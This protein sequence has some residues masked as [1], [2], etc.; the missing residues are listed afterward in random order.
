MAEKKKAYRYFTFLLYPDEFPGSLIKDLASLGVMMISPLHTPYVET[1]PPDN[2]SFSSELRKVAETALA[3]IGFNDDEL[4]DHFHVICKS[5]NKITE[6]SFVSNVCEL[7]HNDLRGISINPQNCGVEAPELLLRY[8]YHLDHPSKQHFD[9]DLMD[10]NVPLAFFKE[11]RSAFQVEIDLWIMAEFEHSSS[12]NNLRNA[13]TGSPFLSWVFWN[14]K[15]TYLI[16]QLY[17]E[18]REVERS[19]YYV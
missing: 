18:Q 14:S 9:F 5:A 6:N 16:S 10:I 11:C 3:E 4:K 12:L 2:V 8:F 17:K 19:Q 13:T 15:N 1:H 7:L